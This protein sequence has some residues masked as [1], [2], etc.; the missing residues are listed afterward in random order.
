MSTVLSTKIL[1][2]SQKN[3]LI[4]TGIGVVEYDAV[5]INIIDFQCDHHIKN[6]I[7]TSQNAA[8]SIFQKDLRIDRCFCVGHKTANMLREQGFNVVETSDY[9]KDL[10]ETIVQKYSEE[11]FTF[12]CG[13]RRREE[14][15][16]LLR[17]RNIKLQ[18]VQVYRTHLDPVTFEQK[19]D[20]IMFFSPSGVKSFISANV[21][22]GSLAFCIGNTTATEAGKHTNKLI[23]ATKPS[24][25][26]V[27]VQV[28][29]N[30]KDDKK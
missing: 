13:N 17:A 20:G 29:K 24:I 15:P 14:L 12:F 9:S 26:N 21:L 2:N 10:A 28:A 11:N 30:F 3:L 27:I 8:R 16:Q 6:S 4:N 22:N 25:E 1:S 19:F 7:I 23:T 18:E 5:K